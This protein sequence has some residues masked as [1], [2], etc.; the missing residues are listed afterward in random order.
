MQ[1]SK[2][3]VATVLILLAV[4]ILVAT[5]YI[6][7][8]FS[9]VTIDQLLFHMNTNLEG[10]SKDVIIN[11][12][13]NCFLSVLVITIILSIPIFMKIFH[14]STIIEVSFK[15][16]VYRHRLKKPILL[17]AFGIF[18]LSIFYA[19][20]VFDI[21]T[22]V[23]NKTTDSKLILNEY[24]DPRNIKIT[25]P[26]EKRNL[27]YIFLESMETTYMDNTSGGGFKTSLISELENL[28]K[29]NL[30]FS[31]TTK[32]GGAVQLTTTH[33]TIAGMVAQTAGLSLKN[34]YLVNKQFL[35][36]AVTLTDILAHENYNQLFLLGSPAKFGDR[37]L[38]FKTHGNVEV[39]DYFEAKK[40]NYIA[41]DY[42]VWWG[43]EDKKLFSNA[44]KELTNLASKKEPFSFIMLTADTHFT[45]GYLDLTCPKKFDTQYENVFA[46]SSLMVKEFID[47]IQ[48]QDFYKNTTIVLTG[49]HLGMQADF[50]KNLNSNYQRTT[51]N[52][53]INSKTTTNN[54]NRL[55]STLDLFPTVLASL[56]VKIEGDRLGL[57]TNLFSNKK[58]LL[59]KY[60]YE[61]VEQEIT[62]NSNFYETYFQNKK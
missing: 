48:K 38:Y 62:K 15:N 24:V 39:V 45:D 21:Q 54:Q 27:I 53:F 32:L 33:F 52:T 40:R 28:A 46:C 12:I 18:I 20:Y 41:N 16:K 50:Y 1:K 31:N 6:S 8:Q 42:N 23:K 51:F 49:D 30:N 60:G 22:Y 36:N 56:N 13:K 2:K 29:E 44:K 35:P 26:K 37:D 7:D 34:N 4:I 3:I 19:L 11:G 55:F 10:D 25:F 57:G 61:Y 47:W 17:Y 43:Y 14:T 58:T 59:E 5:I 9:N